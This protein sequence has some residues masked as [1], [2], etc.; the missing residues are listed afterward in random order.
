MNRFNKADQVLC[1]AAA[2]FAI[3]LAMK[4]N[5]PDAWWARAL[6]FT[7]EAALVG[8]I[9]DWFAVTALFK[10][11]LG[12]PYHTALLPRERKKFIYACTKM[13]QD[14]FFAKKK[15]LLQIKKLN[16]AQQI[17][18]WIEHEDGKVKIAGFLIVLW[19]DMI[20]KIDKK[21]LAGIIETEILQS[22]VAYRQADLYRLI[23]EWVREK[24]LDEALFDRILAVGQHKLAGAETK[25]EIEQFLRTYMAEKTPGVWGGLLSLLAEMTNMVNFH[26][27]ADI[28]QRQLLNLSRELAARENP[29]RRQ[30][31]GQLR[32]GTANL[33]NEASWQNLIDCLQGDLGNHL[34][35]AGEIEKGLQVLLPLL[36]RRESVAEASNAIVVISPP[37]EI[38]AQQI[39]M[40]FSMIKNDVSLQAEI[41]NFVCELLCRSALEAQSMVGT[42][43]GEA[44]DGLSDAELNRL[45]YD[46]VEQ[47]MIWIRMN[48]SI[49]GAII[50]I[51][52]FA[53]LE[54]VG[55]M[56]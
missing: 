55:F 7:S 12:F 19:E 47:D 34:S 49:V 29:L 37:A 43:V 5:Y 56:V 3:C 45:V 41:E 46:K 10:K 30:F 36:K 21:E 31:I 2:L 25:V 22:I 20:D 23:A 48:G 54:L 52:I 9:A 32:T 51:V 40:I 26:E 53:V 1:L 16:L 24:Q 6:F 44:L 42:V 14:E 39:D 15:L 8:G 38:I 13:I 17:M 50:G 28:L 27:A 4:I 35:L 18:A 11:P 33:T